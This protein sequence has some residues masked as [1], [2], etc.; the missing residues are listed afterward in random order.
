MY[1]L[2]SL[3]CKL[4]QLSQTLTQSIVPNR[5]ESRA[6]GIFIAVFAQ[7]LWSLSSAETASDRPSSHHYTFSAPEREDCN[8]QTSSDTGTSQSF[9]ELSRLT[10]PNRPSI[11]PTAQERTS[12][13][14]SHQTITE[15]LKNSKTVWALN[16]DSCALD[17]S[18]TATPCRRYGVLLT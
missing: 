4:L 3:A 9:G 11:R 15:P 7:G 10:E 17:L 13:R 2:E 14:N 16:S 1:K 6:R 5:L 18:F 12:R 8:I